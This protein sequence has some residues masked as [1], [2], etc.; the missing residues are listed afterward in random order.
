MIDNVI[1]WYEID[2]DKRIYKFLSKL[3][4]DSESAKYILEKRPRA[5]Y[6]YFLDCQHNSSLFDLLK[7]YSYFPSLLH[8]IFKTSIFC[9]IFEAFMDSPNKEM[10]VGIRFDRDSHWRNIIFPCSLR[11]PDNPVYKIFFERY[12]TKF[13]QS[14]LDMMI[15][16][17]KRGKRKYAIA[18]SFAYCQLCGLPSD[19][20]LICNAK[21]EIPP[22]ELRNIKLQVNNQVLMVCKETLCKESEFFKNLFSAD[23]KESCKNEFLFPNHSKESFEI[24]IDFLHQEYPI[25]ILIEPTMFIEV[26]KLAN[27]LNCIDLLN[28]FINLISKAESKI[29]FYIPHILMMEDELLG[30]M[31]NL[32]WKIVI[33]HLAS[34][35]D[36]SVIKNYISTG[37]FKKQ[38]VSALLSNGICS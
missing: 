18:L 14:N 38:F 3:L 37:Q 33:T 13:L 34:L 16:K 35:I 20:S 7:R 6:L 21:R 4:S 25:E 24:L 32:A 28:H 9:H 1:E 31:R 2:K 10:L 23:F 29:L 27:E 26:L 36:N 8:L 30:D 19:K 22:Q 15:E 11:K 17:I 5:L 12:D